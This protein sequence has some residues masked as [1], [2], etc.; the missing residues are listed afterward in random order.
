MTMT[1]LEGLQQRRWDALV[2][3]CQA[4]WPAHPDAREPQRVVEGAAKGS[5]SGSGS[6]GGS[7]Q[8]EQEQT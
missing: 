8:Q 1:A 2:A 7:R 4:A 3:G 5:G 6:G